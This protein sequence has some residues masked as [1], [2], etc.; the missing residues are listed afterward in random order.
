MSFLFQELEKAKLAIAEFES[1]LTSERARLRALATEK[2]KAEREKDDIL[3]QLRRTDS[4]NH[5][6]LFH[7]ALI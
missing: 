7:Q 6:Y 1:Q 2:G 4:V 5:D 3:L